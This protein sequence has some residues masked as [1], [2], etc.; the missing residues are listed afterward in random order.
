MTMFIVLLSWQR[1]RFFLR[2]CAI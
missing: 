1:I 2:E